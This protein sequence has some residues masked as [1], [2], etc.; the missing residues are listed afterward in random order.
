MW[1]GS[2]GGGDMD[3]DTDR[4]NRDPALLLFTAPQAELTV[5]V[6]I[7]V[8]VD[9][10]GCLG[11]A[12]DGKLERV[13]EPV[14]GDSPAIGRIETGTRAGFMEA[15]LGARGLIASGGIGA[16]LGDCRRGFARVTREL[17]RQ[18]W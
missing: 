15:R 16:A 11:A 4:T 7:R 1:D 8:D 5:G 3:D 12:G 17:T 10:G 13:V 6:E 18:P 14:P 9:E 2:A